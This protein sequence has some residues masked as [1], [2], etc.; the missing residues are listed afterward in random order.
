MILNRNGKVLIVRWV[1]SSFRAVSAVWHSFSA[2]S[3]HFHKASND[4][5]RQ[6]TKKAKF[7]GLLSKL[8]TSFVKNLALM[9]DLNEL[10]ICQKHWKTEI[11]RYQKLILYLLRIKAIRKPDCFTG[12]VFYF[13]LTSRKSNVIP[14]N[15]ISP[16]IHKV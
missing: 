9:A 4:E 12:G 7:P 14:G 1:A 11:P 6:S 16:V 8:C 2:F 10:N 3:Q 13:S 15:R 5:T